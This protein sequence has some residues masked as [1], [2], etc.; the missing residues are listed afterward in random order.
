[1]LS[2]QWPFQ[3][4]YF[5]SSGIFIAIEGIDGSGTSTHSRLLANWLKRKQIPVYLTHEPT[6]GKIGLLIRDRLRDEL[7]PA[8]TDALLFAADR[9]DHTLQE[10]IPALEQRTVVI[11]DRY[12]ESSITYQTS[13]GLDLEWVAEINRYALTPDLTILLDIEPQIAL[14]RK[15]KPQLKEKFEHIN[16]L[17]KVRKIF[18]ERAKNQGFSIVKTKAPISKVQNQIQKLVEPLLVNL[19]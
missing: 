18:L 13:T 16:F 8:A 14:Q 19:K 9:V 6:N 10:I 3:G 17:T 7:V 11:S 12:V 2:P 4:V 5:M 1:M 15:K